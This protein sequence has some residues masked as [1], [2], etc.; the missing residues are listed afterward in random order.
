[1]FNYSKLSL[2]LSIVVL[3]MVEQPAISHLM[4]LTL[5]PFISNVRITLKLQMFQLYLI[6]PT[7]LHCTVNLY[8]AM[9]RITLYWFHKKLEFIEQNLCFGEIRNVWNR[10]RALKLL[11]FKIGVLKKSLPPSPGP[12]R[13][14]HPE[15]DLYQVQIILKVWQMVTLKPFDL[16]TLYYLYGKI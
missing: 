1:M 7:D 10:A 6:T 8:T 9:N 16:Q 4:V 11:A 14:T 13:T 12:S 5:F 15:F 2:T 3:Y